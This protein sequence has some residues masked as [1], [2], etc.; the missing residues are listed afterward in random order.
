MINFF[1]QQIPTIAKSL[2]SSAVKFV[3]RF[4]KATLAKRTIMLV[5]DGKIRSINLGPFLQISLII[6][7][8]WL[9][10]S[11]L[12]AWQYEKILGF[13]SEEINQ[14]KTSNRYFEE[15]FNNLNEKLRKINDYLISITG[16]NHNVSDESPDFKTPPTIKEE[17]LS[18]RDKQT[19][20]KIKS[21]KSQVASV[22]S[23]THLR[24]KK[25][26]DAISLTGLSLKKVSPKILQ[27]KLGPK[28]KEI[29]LNGNR[30]ITNRQ[31]GP[32]ITKESLEEDFKISSFEA[33]ESLQR[34]LEKIKFVS[35]IDYLMTLEKLTKVMPLSRPMR[36]YYI[37]SGFGSRI[38]PITG[39]LAAHHGL[40]FVG[41]EKEKIIS[42]SKGKVVLAGKYS[43]YG[44]AVV[45]DHGFG[46]TTRYGHLFEV[47]VKE[48][49]MVEKGDVL[50]LQ[51]STGRSTG[52]HLHYE[53]RYKGVP[54]NPRKF[55]EAGEALFNDERSLSN[56]VNS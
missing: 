40:D 35:E 44:N 18:K 11:F 2:I 42:P 15:E 53:V 19:L 52:P 50:A 45:I 20:N 7:A 30:G 46:I 34:E 23:L 48:G 17:N 3:I 1:K 33:E 25:I 24:I 27:E 55:L 54:L 29:S 16:S 37:S 38:D 41:S 12:K 13:K 21:A 32:L 43:D 14:L 31:G 6:V 22:Q 28:M 47:K 56:Y 8:L 49:Q 9:G 39:G 26:E 5:T 4:C 10:D 36:N 51:G